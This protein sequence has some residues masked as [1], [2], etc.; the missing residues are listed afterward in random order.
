M[1]AA[2]RGGA[3]PLLAEGNTAVHAAEREGRP[4]RRPLARAELQAFFDPADDLVERAGCSRRK[5]QLAA[6][7]DA[8]L[9]RVVYGW[10]LRQSRSGSRRC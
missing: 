7:R 3:G 10:G 9:F 2:G 4:Q 6:F 1:R 8:T 5:G